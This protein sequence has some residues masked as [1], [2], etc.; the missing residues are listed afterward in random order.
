MGPTNVVVD[1]GLWQWSGTTERVSADLFLTMADLAHP[2]QRTIP[3]NRSAYS[4]ATVYSAAS[5]ADQHTSLLATHSESYGTAAPS[6]PSSRKVL[7][8]ATLKMTVIF[9]LSTLFLGGT[10]WL[11]LPTLEE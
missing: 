2:Q 8:N 7:V 9:V 11:A 4:M 3:D 6:T 10:L 1:C 5:D